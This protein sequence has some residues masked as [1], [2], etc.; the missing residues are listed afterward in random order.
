MAAAAEGGIDFY[1]N[2]VIN[3]KTGTLESIAWCDERGRSVEDM[4][5]GDWCLMGARTSW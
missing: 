2:I 3:E 1:Y 4:K 5:F